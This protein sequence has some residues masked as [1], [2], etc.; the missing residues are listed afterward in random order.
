MK[1]TWSIGTLSGRDFDL[2]LKSRILPVL[3]DSPTMESL[4]FQKLI[5]FL[6]ARKSNNICKKIIHF[7]IEYQTT[8]L[9]GTADNKHLANAHVLSFHP[10]FLPNSSFFIS[11]PLL[12]PWRG[13]LLQFE[14]SGAV[15]VPFRVPD[16]RYG[17]S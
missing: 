9:E 11:L 8:L 10:Y 7:L 12:S 15:V 4:F 2:P 17:T 5:S 1:C 6:K 3:E 14:K 16:L 13:V